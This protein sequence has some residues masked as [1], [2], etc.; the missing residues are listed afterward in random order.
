MYDA[1]GLCMMRSE[2]SN[3]KLGRLEKDCLFWNLCWKPKTDPDTDSKMVHRWT[4][5]I[6][7]TCKRSWCFTKEIWQQP[8]ATCNNDAHAN[9]PVLFL[10]VF[11]PYQPPKHCTKSYCIDAMQSNDSQSFLECEIEKKIL[12]MS[13]LKQFYSNSLAVW[14]R[15][16]SYN[17]QLDGSAELT[18]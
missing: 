14:D 18:S 6:M 9:V 12:W 1:W 5:K 15:S 16:T 17:D 10:V 3:Y 11:C 13:L 4:I 2:S 8:T 7:E